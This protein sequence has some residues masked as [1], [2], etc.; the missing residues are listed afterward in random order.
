MSNT[1]ILLIVLGLGCL[2]Y[3]LGR[4]RSLA[5]AGGDRRKLHSLPSYYAANVGASAVIPALS[6][7]FL[8]L[9]AQPFLI[10]ASI[11][12]MVDTHARETGQSLSLVMSDVRRVAEGL[13]TAVAEGALSRN[14]ASDT[15]ANPEEIGEALSSVGVALASKV[16]ENTLS[17]AQSYR[18]MAGT[19][20]LI[21]AVAGALV[22]AATCHTGIPGAQCCRTRRPDDLGWCRVHRDFDHDWHC[23]FADL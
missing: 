16:S 6:V 19:G 22:R 12:G 13:D 20:N 1:L 7:L 4:T 23:P 11:S 10:N 17:A 15:A 8:W 9:I 5:V 21:K 3:I 2:G 18:G 14:A